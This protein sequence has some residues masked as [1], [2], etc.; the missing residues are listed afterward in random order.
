[1][2]DDAELNKF[3]KISSRGV[4]GVEELPKLC[5]PF[6]IMAFNEFKN[7]LQD[8]GENTIPKNGPVTQTE[9]ILDKLKVL[10]DVFLYTGTSQ[11]TKRQLKIA[12]SWLVTSVIDDELT[13][14]WVD[15]Y[16]LV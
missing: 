9:I 10:D 3:M 5:R 15:A 2:F 14:P 7:S 8:V 1:M 13:E 12:P 6:S 16:T 11:V 4:S